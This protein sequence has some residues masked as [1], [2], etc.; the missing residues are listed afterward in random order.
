[1]P[2]PDRG[3]SDN[4]CDDACQDAKT[5]D[6]KTRYGKQ[7]KLHLIAQNGDNEAGKSDS[8]ATKA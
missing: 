2:F 1:M 8:K 3:P 6:P 7:S 4:D 5:S